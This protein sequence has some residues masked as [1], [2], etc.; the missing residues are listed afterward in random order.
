MEVEFLLSAS[1]EIHFFFLMIQMTCF[2]SVSHL[3]IVSWICKKIVEEHTHAAVLYLPCVPLGAHMST[4]RVSVAYMC[5]P[6]ASHL[7]SLSLSLAS[8]FF[9]SFSIIPR[10]PLNPLRGCQLVNVSDNLSSLSS[11][12]PTIKMMSELGVLKAYPFTRPG[13]GV[14]ALEAVQCQQSAARWIYYYHDGEKEF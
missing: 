11:E 5:W 2:G 3:S 10:L 9:L 1:S 14:A 8:L 6:R 13:D 7:G 12:R 4:E